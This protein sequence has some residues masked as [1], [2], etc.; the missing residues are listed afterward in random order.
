MGQ[1]LLVFGRLARAPSE[2]CGRCLLTKLGLAQFTARLFGR[3]ADDWHRASNI[4]DALPPHKAAL[5]YSRPICA[6]THN[7]TIT[8]KPPER[9]GEPTALPHRP[10]RE[11]AK[12]QLV[13]A[14]EPGENPAKEPGPTQLLYTR[15]SRLKYKL[16]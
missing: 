1:R 14:V 12:G 13:G 3:L 8:A 2:K 7:A 5:L 6:T 15:A 11:H 16:G 4:F 9:L 10:R